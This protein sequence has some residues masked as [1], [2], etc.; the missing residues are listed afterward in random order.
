M[1]ERQVLDV[2]TELDKAM[3]RAKAIWDRFQI[4]LPARVPRMPWEK[5]PEYVRRSFSAAVAEQ[6]ETWSR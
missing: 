6:F 4:L 1:S 3:D 2:Q 5:L